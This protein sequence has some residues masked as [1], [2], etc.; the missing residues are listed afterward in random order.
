MSP[1]DDDGVAD[2]VAV[3]VVSADGAPEGDGS[4]VG[5]VVGFDVVGG[6]VSTPVGGVDV[7]GVGVD[8][9]A[10]PLFGSCGAPIP[11]ANANEARTRFRTPRAT[12]RRAR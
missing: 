9:T 8:W 1:P 10:I 2:A 5:S 6:S 4:V 7:A 3:G 12:T 11:T